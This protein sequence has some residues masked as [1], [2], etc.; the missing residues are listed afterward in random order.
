MADLT[1]MK[2]AVSSLKNKNNNKKKK[3]QSRLL[4]LR[5]YHMKNTNSCVMSMMMV[6]CEKISKY[7]AL[8]GN[9]KGTNQNI[10]EVL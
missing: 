2:H 9:C 6:L 8:S 7:Y 4:F 1:S 5:K 3:K 10:D